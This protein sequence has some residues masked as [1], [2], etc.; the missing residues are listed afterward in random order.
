MLLSAVWFMRHVCG[1]SCCKI[2]AVLDT[3]FVLLVFSDIA[4]TIIQYVADK[5][6]ENFRETKSK[7]SLTWQYLETLSYLRNNHGGAWRIYIAVVGK[8]TF[9]L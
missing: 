7:E 4:G 8:L 1:S 3:A 9:W 5:A 6:N 2:N